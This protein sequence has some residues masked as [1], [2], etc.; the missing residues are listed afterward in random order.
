[1]FHVRVIAP[2]DEARR[3]L[4]LFEAAP[5]AT[6]VVHEPGQA[7]K[8]QGDVVAAD[9]G[10]D[11][12]SMLLADLEEMGI[13]R[14]GAITV[15]PIDVALSRDVSAI[16]ARTE[17]AGTGAVVW[18][19]VAARSSEWTEL[20]GEYL[21]FMALAV[22]IA[23]V[24]LITQSVVLI[25]GAMILG[26]DYGPLAGVCVALFERHRDALRRSFVA[27]AAGF[28]L[29]VLTAWLFTEV[30]LA[31]GLVPSSR[32][33]AAFLANIIA[34]PNRWSVVV[35]LA[36]GV[37]GMLS[38]TTV[39]SGALVGVLVS[40]TTI[41]ALANAGLATAYSSWSDALGSLLLLGVNVGSIVAAG[42]ATLA[43]ERALYRRRRR[44]YRSGPGRRAAGL[45][46]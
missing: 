12:A 30:A 44:R 3:A 28:G 20:D 17:R 40:I 43:V 15:I 2:P 42:L 23:V 14:A 7:H 32:K 13:P 22:I 8:P 33:E 27:L 10:R 36:A 21:A 5:E 31:L 6:N 4:R 41:P 11:A 16:R 1:V 35:A 46:G 25:I 29:A 45:P 39:K 26:P 38:L 24:G 19:E 37:A 9:V 34:E 18:E